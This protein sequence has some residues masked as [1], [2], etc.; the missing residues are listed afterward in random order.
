MTDD[1]VTFLLQ[2]NSIIP[3]LG[4]LVIRS[5]NKISN[6]YLSIKCCSRLLYFLWQHR[7]CWQM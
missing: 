5:R 6:R 3:Y 2:P 7:Q 4:Q 1:M